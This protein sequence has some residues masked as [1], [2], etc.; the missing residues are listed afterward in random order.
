MSSI[1]KKT[2]LVNPPTVGAQPNIDELTSALDAAS[3]RSLEELLPSLDKDTKLAI[4]GHTLDM[5]VEWHPIYN[6]LA[7]FKKR[8]IEVHGKNQKLKDA[9]KEPSSLINRI[10]ELK[11]YN[12]SIKQ[13][14]QDMDIIKRTILSWD[15]LGSEGEWTTKTG[16]EGAVYVRKD[17][18]TQDVPVKELIEEIQWYGLSE[19]DAIRLFVLIAWL[20]KTGCQNVGGY[21]QNVGYCGYY[22]FTATKNSRIWYLYFSDSDAALEYG[23]DTLAINSFGAT[24]DH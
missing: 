18:L 17:G 12:P 13:E 23:F 9:L 6:H 24:S 3:N 1:N 10:K 15:Q 14:E 21:W 5:A 16:V 4:E 8:L 2:I 11:L 22:A 20:P 7:L 19:D